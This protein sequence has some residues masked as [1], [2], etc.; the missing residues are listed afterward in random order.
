[1]A[2]DLIELDAPHRLVRA[3]ILGQDLE[4]LRGRQ[5]SKVNDRWQTSWRHST[6]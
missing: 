3:V 4:T 2:T 6:R 1:V 5:V